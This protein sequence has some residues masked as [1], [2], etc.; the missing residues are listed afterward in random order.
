MSSCI[1]WKLLDG[2]E[3]VEAIRAINEEF[4][5]PVVAFTTWEYL[6]QELPLSNG[7]KQ[8]LG[9]RYSYSGFYREQIGRIR[10]LSMRELDLE[11]A[12]L[13]DRL[14][15]KNNA[16]LFSYDRHFSKIKGY[17]QCRN[18]QLLTLLFAAKILTENSPVC[19]FCG[20]EA[21]LWNVLADALLNRGVP[22]FIV[23]PGRFHANR[24][25]ALT[26]EGQVLGMRQTFEAL[27]VGKTHE[28]PQEELTA[29][30]SWLEDF[31]HRP[32]TPWATV[33][34]T[35]SLANCAKSLWRSGVAS[36]VRNSRLYAQ[37]VFDREAGLL[38]STT[39][40]LARWPAKTLRML[41]LDRGGLMDKEPD[42]SAEYIYLPLHM[43]PEVT[44]LYYGRDYTHHAAFVTQL[45]KRIPSECRIY[46]KEHVNM[47][48][49]RPLHFYQE[50]NRLYNVTVIHPGVSSISL[51]KSSKAVL[52]VTGTA[53]WEAYLL[54][55]PAIV[56][57][58]VF[59]NFLPG[60]LHANLYAPDFTE[61]LRQYLDGF[62]PNMEERRAAARAQYLN[63]YPITDDGLPGLD[64]VR[65]KTAKMARMFR[66][67]LAT[68]G[69]A[70]VASR[71]G[72]Q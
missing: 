69:N 65:R 62:T 48:G 71:Q 10:S 25:T 13:E 4:Q 34:S 21:Y 8:D 29:A 63:S 28:F 6:E 54:G 27:L 36:L 44:D 55:K 59:Y 22:T 11:Q 3:D 42:L 39:A 30:D 2:V 9:I 53:G 68:W 61:K 64:G 57:G 41:A 38:D 35:R 58:D 67:V 19:F 72:Q 24:Y 7:E 49:M 51:I 56:L 46:V 50:L 60:V 40:T 14:G 17:R 15:I 20:R 18:I 1:L 70:V 33:G 32:P 66:H 12:K 23:D 37:N 52:T 5:L 43:T 47:L 45:S 31:L 16:M 26:P